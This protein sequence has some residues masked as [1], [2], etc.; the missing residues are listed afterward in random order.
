MNKTY[1][2]CRPGDP[3]RFILHL[4]KKDNPIIESTDVV[5]YRTLKL[6]QFFNAIGVRN[7]GGYEEVEVSTP[8]R[9]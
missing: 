6:L 5:I 2:I 9:R 7:L 8:Y 3:G 4:S 1:G